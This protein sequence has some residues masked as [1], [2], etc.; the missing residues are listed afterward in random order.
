M[1]SHSKKKRQETTLIIKVID[2]KMIDVGDILM[3]NLGKVG[4]NII[5]RDYSQVLSYG[6]WAGLR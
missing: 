6:Y 3:T 2:K 1:S 4:Q 5:V